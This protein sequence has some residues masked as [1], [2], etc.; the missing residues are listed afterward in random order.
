M[1]LQIMIANKHPSIINIGNCD[2]VCFSAESLE[3]AR[4]SKDS[5]SNASVAPLTP[6]NITSIDL[7][8]LTPDDEAIKLAAQQQRNAPTKI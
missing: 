3:H 6:L 7:R 1:P 2:R 8:G 4:I 5:I